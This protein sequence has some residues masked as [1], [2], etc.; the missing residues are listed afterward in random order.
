[1]GIA[2]SDGVSIYYERH[3]SGP[4][5]LLV[6][7][8]GGHHAA[9]WQQVAALRGR[10][11]VVTVDLRGFG[12]SDSSM[13]EFDGQDFPGDILA[14]LDQEDLTD[15]LLVGQSIGA[16]AAL[17]AGLAR[18]ARVA[19]VALAHSLGGIADPSLSELVAADRAEA[20]K[21]PVLDRLLT[22]EFQ[23]SEPAKTFLF[24][25]MGTF[26]VAKMADLRNLSTGGPTI[27]EVVGSGLDV[28]FLAGE[29]D[30]VLSAATVRRAH[31]LVK[32]SRLELIPDAPHSMY[33]E[34]PLLFNAAVTRIR[35]AL[36]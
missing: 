14:V 30:A 12:N 18:P 20:V 26:N 1:M 3:G 33:W 27:G 23:Q 7:G 36:A 32:G 8:S 2:K 34:A 6:H 9:W 10:F 29:K 11:T 13:P 21:L 25:Q 22:K 5:I 31:E 15:V 24:Q 35:E 19:G 4:A 28:T 17:R 16:V